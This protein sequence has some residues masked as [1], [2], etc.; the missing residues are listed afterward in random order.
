MIK[1]AVIGDPIGHSKSPLIHGYW[2]E[3]YGLEGSYEAIQVSSNAL[4]EKVKSLVDQGYT[5]FNVTIPHKEAIMALCDEVDAT[6][7]AIGAVNAVT[8]QDGFVTGYNTDAFGFIEN[9]LQARPGFDFEKGPAFVLGA[10]GAA[11]AVIYGLLKAGAPHVILTNRTTGK[12]DELKA[13]Y[14]AALEVVDWQEKENHLANAN[15]CVNTTSLGMKSKPELEINLENLPRDALVSDI[16]Y[17]P[18]ETTL[19][20]SA[21]SLGN[22]TVSG[23]GMLLHQA[24]PAFEKWF[25]VMPEVT[26]ELQDLVLK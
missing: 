6:A 11:R 8:I 17:A 1:A 22:P 25:G 26:T 15:I 4:K 24:R 16:V 14:G 10:G 19:L 12:A 9:I 3:K 5:G 7:L 2:I 18:L 23:I 21:K 20:K 13:E